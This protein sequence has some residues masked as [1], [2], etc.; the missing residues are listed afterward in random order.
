MRVAAYMIPLLLVVCWN[1]GSKSCESFVY[2][3]SSHQ[4][5]NLYIRDAAQRLKFWNDAFGFRRVVRF[6]SIFSPPHLDQFHFCFKILSPFF[7]ICSILW[8]SKTV[9]IS[10]KVCMIRVP[11]MG[12]NIYTQQLENKNILH[13]RWLVQGCYIFIPSR[14]IM[15]QFIP[16]I[17]SRKMNAV[18]TISG[19]LLC[20]TIQIAY[21]SCTRKAQKNPYLFWQAFLRSTPPGRK[22][23]CKIS[24]YAPAVYL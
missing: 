18:N 15:N 3:W 13:R 17:P 16:F 23:K 4:N 24:F 21:F 10:R 7:I 1:I 14:I 8:T 5:L 6:K 19:G 11:K 9:E 22:M 12:Y 2:S 20:R